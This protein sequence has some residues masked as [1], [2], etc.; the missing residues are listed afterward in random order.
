VLG[1][2]GAQPLGAEVAQHHPE[3]QRAEAAPELHAGV[4]QVLHR[5]GLDGL[6]VLGVSAN[7]CRTTS[8]RRQ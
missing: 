1:E 7:A 4:H 6:Q 5:R 2:P 8:M 3:L